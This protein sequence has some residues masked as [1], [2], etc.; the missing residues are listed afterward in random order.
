MSA[1][2]TIFQHSLRYHVEVTDEPD[3]PDSLPCEWYFDAAYD[4]E[5]TALTHAQ[6]LLPVWRAVRVVDTATSATTSSKCGC[7]VRPEPVD[8]VFPFRISR[9]HHTKDVA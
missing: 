2:A 9:S 1:P 6:G 8:N 3:A 4:D 7:Y 5:A